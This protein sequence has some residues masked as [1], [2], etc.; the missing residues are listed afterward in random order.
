MTSSI[1]IIAVDTVGRSSW[2][3]ASDNMRIKKS[4]GF[5]KRGQSWPKRV[6]TSSWR[7]TGVLIFFSPLFSFS[8]SLSLSHTYWSKMFSCGFC[9]AVVNNLAAREQNEIIKERKNFRVGLMDL[10]NGKPQEKKKEE[11]MLAFFFFFFFQENN[12]VRKRKTK[13]CIGFL[14]SSLLPFFPSFCFSSIFSLLP[15]LFFSSSTSS[16]LPLLPPSLRYFSYCACDRSS[17]MRKLC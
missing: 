15:L 11:D 8:L 16:S 12:K 10:K 2:M 17:A 9:G 13:I 1:V 5:E 14:F 7:S 3:T 4:A 6:M